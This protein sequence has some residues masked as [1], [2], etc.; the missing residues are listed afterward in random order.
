MAIYQPAGC[1]AN[2]ITSE[3]MLTH[4]CLYILSLATHGDSLQHDW[5]KL[6][7]EVS[8]FPTKIHPTFIIL[9]MSLRWSS[10]YSVQKF[11]YQ[12]RLRQLDEEIHIE[13][14]LGSS[15]VTS[16]RKVFFSWSGSDGDWWRYALI[17]HQTTY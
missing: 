10:L 5:A 1:L 13:T 9:N 8:N 2:L 3:V 11:L 17:L 15:E 14:T 12:F 7:L 4:R 16:N 6:M